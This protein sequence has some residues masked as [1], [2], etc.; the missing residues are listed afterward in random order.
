MLT[1]RGPTGTR[2]LMLSNRNRP[3]VRVARLHASAK[4]A[5]GAA[6][7]TVRSR[8]AGRADGRTAGISIVLTDAGGRV[9][10]SRAVLRSGARDDRALVRIPVRSRG[11]LK[12][13]VRATALAV[14]DGDGDSDPSRHGS[15]QPAER[16]FLV[17]ARL[18]AAPR[19]R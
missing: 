11:R 7:V 14:A 2:R 5:T 6:V 4:R 9:K 19:R 10:A 15:P 13:R 18:D 3:S 1:V 8:L 12:V 17:R 16:R